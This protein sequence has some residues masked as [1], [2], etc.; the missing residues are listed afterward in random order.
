MP[1][2]ENKGDDDGAPDTSFDKGLLLF[3]KFHRDE[4]PL[5]TLEGITKSLD[6]HAENVAYIDYTLYAEDCILRFV[7][8]ESLK[9]YTGSRGGRDIAD[10][11]GDWRILEGEEEIKYWGSLHEA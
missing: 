10:L 9:A 5:H 3:I 8:V 1:K 11:A 7:S 2:T 6:Q 4:V